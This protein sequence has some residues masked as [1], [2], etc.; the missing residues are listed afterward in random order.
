[1]KKE[2]QELF[3][4]EMKLKKID[5]ETKVHPTKHNHYSSYYTDETRELVAKHY[6]LDIE[7]FGYTFNTN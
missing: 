3:I 4:N 7:Y 2:L 5:L 1:M 6:S